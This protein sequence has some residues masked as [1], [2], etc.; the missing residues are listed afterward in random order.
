MD[1]CC[2]RRPRSECRR[3]GSDEA[4]VDQ[5]N[6]GFFPN[7]THAPALVGLETGLFAAALGDEVELNTFTFNAGTEATEALFAEAIDIAFIGP[8]PA[9]NAWAQSD[10]TA[11]RIIAGSTSG[12]ASL[13]VRPDIT[14]VEQLAGRML[15]TPSLGNTQDVALRA[16]LAD[17][18]LEST[19]DGGG[20]VTILPQ[21]NATTLE[22]FVGGA[23]DG[24]LG[25][26]TVGLRLV[27]AGGGR[28]LVDERDLWP[29]TDGE[30]VTTDVVVRT[31]Y[32]EEHPDIV[33]AFLSGLLASLD[34]IDADPEAALAAV[35]ARIDATTGQTSDPDVISAS[36][37]NLTFT[38]DPIAASLQ[39]SADDAIAVGLLEPVDL[40][41]IH[42]LTLLN[43]LLAVRGETEVTGL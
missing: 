37:A 7:V 43:E 39:G 29:D 3:A 13:V 36:F 21:S 25:A 41:G 12:G 4:L 10:G 22:S 18:G 1:R 38:W 8:N 23:I 35:I 5:L 15:A 27:A 17:Q 31:A 33:R 9:I 11:I 20:D 24:A 26:R 34:S 42:E 30:Y 19:P 16:W 28:V 32:L 6:L 2:A 40:A 14:D